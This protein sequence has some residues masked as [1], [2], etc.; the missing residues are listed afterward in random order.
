M[1]GGS[2]QVVVSRWQVEGM[3][4]NC[5]GAVRKAG[6]RCGV[7]AGSGGGKFVT[8]Q[9]EQEEEEQ[10]YSQHTMY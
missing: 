8:Q 2:W 4:P 1:A 6:S 10:Q 3:W 5:L 9:E 7:A